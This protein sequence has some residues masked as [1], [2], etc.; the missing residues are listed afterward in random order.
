[1]PL[2][3]V[4][5]DSSNA[6]YFDNLQFLRHTLVLLNAQF[7]PLTFSLLV[8]SLSPSDI[9]KASNIKAEAK[10]KADEAR[11]RT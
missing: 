10:A 3:A 1:M 5:R 9:S 8:L 7:I 2:H 11:P 6:N 4:C